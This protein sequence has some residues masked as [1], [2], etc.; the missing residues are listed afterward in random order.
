MKKII[1]LLFITT[2]TFAQNSS[3]SSFKESLEKI[4]YKNFV[5]TVVAVDNR[6]IKRIRVFIKSPMVKNDE[7]D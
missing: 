3:D 2:A 6:R 7:L 5:F 1:F 4:E